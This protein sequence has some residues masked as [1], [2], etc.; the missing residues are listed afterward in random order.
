MQNVLII[1]TCNKLPPVF[2]TFVL[3][4]LSDRLRLLYIKGRSLRSVLV[5]GCGGCIR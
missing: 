2:I 4:I 1:S 5:G 3:S